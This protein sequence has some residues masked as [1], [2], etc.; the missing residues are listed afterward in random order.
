[1][2]G[3]VGRPRKNQADDAVD[4]G[5]VAVAKHKYSHLIFLA[6]TLLVGFIGAQ[7]GRLF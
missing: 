6:Y 7:I 5:L 3:K 4:K 2:P 1:M